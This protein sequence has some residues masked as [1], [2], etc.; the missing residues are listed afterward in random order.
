MLELS[1]EGAQLR[2]D[3]WQALV[4]RAEAAG[5]RREL[6]RIGANLNQVPARCMAS[7]GARRSATC[8]LAPFTLL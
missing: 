5:Q 8:G 3:E 1:S 7:A 6:R 4:A 2:D